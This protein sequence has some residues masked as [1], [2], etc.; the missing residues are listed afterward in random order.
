A[1]FLGGQRDVAGRYR[2]AEHAAGRADEEAHEDQPKLRREQQRGAGDPY[3]DEAE[4]EI[5]PTETRD[6]AAGPGRDRGAAQ[7]A[8]EQGAEQRAG[9]VVGRRREVEADVGEGRDEVE[10]R[11]EADR[12]GREE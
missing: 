7:I 1:P 4:H 11:A 9:E 8:E 3:R 6:E 12:K 2:L 10:Q 5:A